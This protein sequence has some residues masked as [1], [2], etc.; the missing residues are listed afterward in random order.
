MKKSFKKFLILLL[1]S[2]LTFIF[3]FEILIPI[4]SIAAFAGGS[5]TNK[6]EIKVEKEGYL[7]S[8]I[9]PL[10]NQPFFDVLESKY[11]TWKRNP[12]GN[13]VSKSPQESLINFYALMAIVG[14]RV[15]LISNSASSDPGFTWS[16]KAKHQIEETEHL[17]ELA[18]N[19]LDASDFPESVRSHLADESAIEIKQ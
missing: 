11:E 7:Y 16:E 2:F 1:S 6:S 17:F 9:I 19:S 10:N 15:N 14:D 18:V 5:T 8:D 4:S 3:L 12:I 13:V